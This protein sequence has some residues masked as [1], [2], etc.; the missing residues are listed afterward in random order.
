MEMDTSPHPTNGNGALSFVVNINI[1]NGATAN[2]PAQVTPPVEMMSVKVILP[3]D[4]KTQVKI[5][6]QATVTDL[7]FELRKLLLTRYPAKRVEDV[8]LDK[9]TLKSRMG[10]ALN[11]ADRVCDVVHEESVVYCFYTD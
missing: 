9:L 10:W 11:L 4:F 6:S 1:P 2:S 3:D 7:R 8:P 5:S